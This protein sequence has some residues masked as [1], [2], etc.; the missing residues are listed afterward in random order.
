MKKLLLL[1]VLA[2]SLV[3]GVSYYTGS[4][5]SAEPNTPQSI[6]K[7]VWQEGEKI[8]YANKHMVVEFT[9]VKGKNVIEYKTGNN[10]E[11]KSE[12]L[13]SPDQWQIGLIEI[14]DGEKF[15]TYYPDMSALSIRNGE[16]GEKVIPNLLFSEVMKS[17]VR[18]EAV[19]KQSGVN[20]EIFVR[21]ESRQIMTDAKGSDI[22]QQK[23]VNVKTNY[24]LDKQ[25][26]MITKV[27]TYNAD[28]NQLLNKMELNVFE[29][30]TYD[31][32]EFVFDQ[33]KVKTIID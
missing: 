24:T 14:W 21:N 12:I 3:T 8:P 5:N 4:A 31:S 25:Q 28:N 23:K 9:D 16:K 32:S 17:R 7:P 13:E 11:W 30:A 2:I 20:H 15:Y 10:G 6:Q 18:K 27:E 19:L 33:S 26:E 22:S 29:N 1:F